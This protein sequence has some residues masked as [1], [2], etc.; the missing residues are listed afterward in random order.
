MTFLQA[1][2]STLGK[3]ATFQGR[4]PRSEFW[5]FT[6]FTILVQWVSSIVDVLI[7][8]TFSFMHYG[9]VQAFTPINSL[10]NLA[11]LIPSIAL[12]ARRFHD[13]N[14]TGWWQLL[15]FTGI[16]ALVI[17]FW[18]MF[19]GTEGPNRFGPDTLARY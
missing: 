9:D 12:S 8:G 16:G 19:K 10:A 18:F 4:A 11:L 3:Y 14:R 15:I 6:L 7:F 17:F 2:S 13:M 1:V 5:W